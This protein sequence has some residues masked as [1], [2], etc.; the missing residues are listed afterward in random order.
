MPAIYRESAQKG[1]SKHLGR[2]AELGRVF[3]LPRFGPGLRS[4]QN[5]Y[6]M[7]ARQ[8]SRLGFERELWRQGITLVAGVDEAGCGPLA[9]P[10]AAAAV[11]LPHSWLETGLDSKFRGLNDS[12]QLTE[13]QREKYYTVI[14]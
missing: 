10:V 6:P 3:R 4:P 8:I 2:V 7:S 9:G 1:S 5:I 13:E 11:I 14:T 12:K